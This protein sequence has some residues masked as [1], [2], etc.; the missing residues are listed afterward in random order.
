MPEWVLLSYRVPR[1]PT[2]ARVYVWR[3]LKRLGAALVNG[4]VWAL[5]HTP[6][7]LEQVQWL[8][9]EIQELKGRAM[10]WIGNAHPASTDAALVRELRDRADAEFARIAAKAGRKSRNLDVHGREFREACARDYFQSPLREKARHALLAEPGTGRPRARRL[11]RR[12]RST[13]P[14]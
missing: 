2:A 1:D 5:P 9:S 10:V 6:F 8:A 12:P 7:T 3:R 13:T 14:P 11:R 4:S